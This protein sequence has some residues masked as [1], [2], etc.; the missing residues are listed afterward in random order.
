MRQ[1]STQVDSLLQQAQQLPS[2]DLGP[3]YEPPPVEF[4]FETTGWAILGG[5]FLL[6]VLVILFFMLRHYL[7]NRYRKEALTS[8]YEIESDASAFPKVFVIL[9]RVA[10]QVF[11]REKVGSLHGNSWLGFLD[12]TGKDV[13]LLQFE[14]QISALIYQD[15]IPDQEVRKEIMSQAQKWIK[16]HAGK[17]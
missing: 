10:I 17:L 5:M 11:G 9:K 15:R 13:R 6:G 16:T 7:R 12:K 14:E 8:L 1:D 2:A 4:S 3:I